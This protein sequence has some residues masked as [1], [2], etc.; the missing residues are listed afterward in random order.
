MAFLKFIDDVGAK[1]I[2]NG[3]LRF[4]LVKRYRDQENAAV[5]GKQDFEEGRFFTQKYTTPNGSAINVRFEP[6]EDIG[7]ALCLYRMSDEI[8]VNGLKRMTEFGEFV[9]VIKDEQEF[10]RRLDIATQA[11]E[12]MF[13]RRDVFYYDESIEDEIEVMKLLSLG[14]EYFPFLKRKADFSYQKEYRYLIIDVAKSE[15]K[16]IKVNV[17]KL[18]DVA[19]IQ[20]A[21]RLLKNICDTG[22]QINRT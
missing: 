5:V 13:L 9:V 7:H 4:G 16:W 12:Y 17:G 10:I 8:D 20:L 18:Y 14:K 11:L 1:S 22:F 15:E 21:D 3:N 6:D 2:L 19:E